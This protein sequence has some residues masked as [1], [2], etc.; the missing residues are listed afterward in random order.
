[1][2]CSHVDSI[3]AALVCFPSDL[4]EL[5]E[6]LFGSIPAQNMQ[7]ALQK[8]AA[9]LEA[10]TNASIEL[11]LYRYSFLDQYYHKDRGF[12]LSMTPAKQNPGQIE[13]KQGCR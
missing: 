10:T 6:K 12:A 13:V 5:F 11:L 8:L 3:L 2:R 4:G 9:V 1:M 7:S